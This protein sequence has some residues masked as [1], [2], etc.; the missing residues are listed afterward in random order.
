MM[1]ISRTPDPYV[2]PALKAL[3]ASG[4][5]V[6]G[7]LSNTVAFPPGI[8]DDRGVLFG[9]ELRHP[10]NTPHANDGTAIVDRFDI[11][12]SSAHVGLRKPDPKIYELAVRELDA[13]ARRQGLGGVNVG[14]VLFLDDIG[15]NLKGAKSVGM[16]TLKVD[17]GKTE[18]AVRELEELTGVKLLEGVQDRA[19]L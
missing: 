18:A 15:A 2:Y 17:L 10:P 11:F 9:S 6:L 14:D 19:R 16:R 1:R 5:F 3:R 4:K 13:E 12:V 8:R 7:A